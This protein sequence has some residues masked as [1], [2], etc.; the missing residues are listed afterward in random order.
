MSISGGSDFVKYFTSVDFLHE[1]DIMNMPDNGKGYKPGFFY[2]R[3]N[4]RANL[5]FKLTNSTTLSANIAGLQGNKQ[6]SWSGF[7]YSWYQG[8]YGNAPDLFYPQYT[9][10]TYGYYPLDPV[11]TNNPAQILGN[12][13]VRN[14]KTTQIQLILC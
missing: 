4:I 6:D 11:S 9:D 2:D 7:E 13:G 12:N 10:G 1:G 5:D 14:T 8:I 3:L